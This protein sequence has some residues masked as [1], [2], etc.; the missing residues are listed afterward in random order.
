[1]GAEAE[2]LQALASVVEAMDS[3]GI[4]YRL[5]GSV[6]S[7]THGRPRATND[8][9]LVADIRQEH[10]QPLCARLR[11][12]FYAEDELLV[13]AVR[14]QSCCNFIHLASIYKID[15]FVRKDTAYDRAA[16]ERFTTKPLEDRPDAR[17]F[18][19]CTIEDTILNKLRWHEAGGCVSTS[20]WSDILGMIALRFDTLDVAYLRTWAT[21]LGLSTLLDRAL[22]EAANQR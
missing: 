7:S 14:T 4:R 11:P 9:D 16:F 15:V 2:A 1:L 3:L 20:Q 19:I 6:A 5:T 17:Q 13:E 10:V 18:P 8:V 22:Q 12:A 21:D